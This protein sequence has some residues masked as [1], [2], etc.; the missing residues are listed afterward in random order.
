MLEI[1]ADLT[2]IDPCPSCGDIS[3]LTHE[4][5]ANGRHI[6]VCLTCDAQYPVSDDD[7]PET[8]EQ[9]SCSNEQC[10]KECPAA[11]VSHETADETHLGACTPAD[12]PKSGVKYDQDK[13][14]WHLIPWQAVRAVAWILTG[15]AVKY[16]DRNW[17][18]GMLYSRLFRAAQ[19]HLNDFWHGKDT[20]EEDFGM[21]HVAHA[22]CCVLMLLHFAL[23][24]RRYAP[25]DDRPLDHRTPDVDLDYKDHMAHIKD[26]FA[27]GREVGGDTAGGKPR[28]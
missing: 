25:F 11:S 16:A 6:L 26:K 3:G 13:V 4:T 24:Y 20:N 15:G 2:G 12:L 18:K 10:C 17:E 23:F 7:E 27:R 19:S 1:R 14:A 8:C 5:L 9:N 22:A 28:V 21:L